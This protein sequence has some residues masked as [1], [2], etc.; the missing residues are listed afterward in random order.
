MD[1]YHDILLLKRE[2]LIE[3]E[4]KNKPISRDRASCP[5]LSYWALLFLFQIKIVPRSRLHLEQP[6]R[7]KNLKSIFWVRPLFLRPAETHGEIRPLLS[8]FDTWWIWC[9]ITTCSPS[10]PSFFPFPPLRAHLILKFSFSG[11]SRSTWNT[12][13]SFN[14]EPKYMHSIIFWISNYGTGQAVRHVCVSDDIFHFY[15]LDEVM[16]FEIGHSVLLLL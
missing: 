9:R 15:V 8:W 11:C 12:W 1:W 6:N 7:W 3:F 10:L 4:Q 13:N 14:L 2:N 5:P 16:I